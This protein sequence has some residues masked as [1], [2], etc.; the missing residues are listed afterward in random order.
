MLWLVDTQQRTKTTAG[1]LKRAARWLYRHIRYDIYAYIPPQIRR[2]EHVSTCGSKS[3][4]LR[5][6]SEKVRVL[7]SM[8]EQRPGLGR[9][10][11]QRGTLTSARCR[12]G[13]TQPCSGPHK[14]QAADCGLA[15]TPAARPSTSST[16]IMSRI[17]GYET[18]L[19]T[20]CEAPDKEAMPDRLSI[21]LMV[22][23][24]LAGWQVTE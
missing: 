23:R 22:R 19:C 20:I 15:R 14:L 2:Y 17:G 10:R 12:P 5:A 21:L 8:Y 7:R 18:L 4:T 9:K 11:K 16:T 24:N 3:P 6:S 1:I 13:N